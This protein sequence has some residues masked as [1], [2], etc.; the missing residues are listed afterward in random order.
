MAEA[1]VLRLHSAFERLGEDDPGLA[2]RVLRAHAKVA[3]ESQRYEEAIE[4]FDRAA[5]EHLRDHQP[6]MAVTAYAGQGDG[7]RI[8]AA[9]AQAY[10]SKPISVARFVAEVSALLPKEAVVQ[11]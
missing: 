3:A 1:L 11:A 2:A 7:D 8:C 10:V 9:G 6:I 5:R 4:L